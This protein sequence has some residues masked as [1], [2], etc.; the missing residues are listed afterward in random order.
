LPLL[1]FDLA[2][3][4]K[5][6]SPRRRSAELGEKSTFQHYMIIPFAMI[7]RGQIQNLF[8]KPKLRVFLDTSYKTCYIA[9]DTKIH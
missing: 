2:P 5:E 4:H 7:V 3:S 6:N 8:A 9:R 1:S